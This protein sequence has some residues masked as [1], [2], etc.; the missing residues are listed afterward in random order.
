VSA[1][2]QRNRKFVSKGYIDEKRSLWICSQAESTEALR[3]VNPC[4][5]HPV[6]KAPYGTETDRRRDVDKQ[7]ERKEEESNGPERL[8]AIGHREQWNRGTVQGNREV[9]RSLVCS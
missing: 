1:D 9:D 8:D 6:A 7:D 3:R 2:L 5:F 4:S